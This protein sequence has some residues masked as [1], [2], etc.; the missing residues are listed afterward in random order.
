MFSRLL[1]L[2]LCTYLYYSPVSSSVIEEDDF[3]FLKCTYPEL[4]E[5]AAKSFKNEGAE[6]YASSFNA[7]KIHTNIEVV[8]TILNMKV[9][10]PKFYSDINYHDFIDNQAEAFTALEEHVGNEGLFN[11]FFQR[12][13]AQHN[14]V[15]D[16]LLAGEYIYQILQDDDTPSTVLFLGRTPCLV[17]KAYESAVDRFGGR[18]H[19]QSIHLHF[20][21]HPDAETM[22]TA[23]LGHQKK[24]RMR[25]MVT[26]EKLAHYIAYMKQKGLSDVSKLYIVDMMGTGGGLN[27]FM[28][29]LNEFYRRESS[30]LPD[31]TF[32]LLSGNITI[33]SFPEVKSYQLQSIQD[34]VGEMYVNFNEDKV[35]NL[36]P[37]SI[38]T[39][40]V[41]ITDVSIQ[42]VLDYDF[43]QY[44]ASHGV[45]YPA[46]RWVPEF[47]KE[48]ENVGA[49]KESFYAY[50]QK[51]FDYY[52]ERHSKINSQ[53]GS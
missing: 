4:E 45:E 11:V 26:E 18:K 52:L 20:S 44:F 8:K 15:E 48:R 53:K 21:G 46:Q 30:E 10:D 23:Y 14:V 47:D 22:R 17:Q 37:F 50:V 42:N 49:Y 41:P 40:I 1:L 35:I 33:N 28:R 36:K 38:K 9:Y 51:R 19:H 32:L 13:K 29:I 31:I 12:K 5:D 24:T 39:R 25:N 34:S 7:Y 27:S 16:I 43:L 2:F 3:S 6:D